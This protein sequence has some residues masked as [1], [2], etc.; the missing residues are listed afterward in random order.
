MKF[1][2]MLSAS[3]LTFVL[4]CTGCHQ[5]PSPEE[6]AE[7]DKVEIGQWMDSFAKAVD[8][9]DV[10][11]IMALY[12][13]DVLVYDLTP[14]LEYDGADA[15]RKDWAGFF[16]TVQL[17]LQMEVRDLRITSGGDV[18]FVTNL[19]RIT[20]TSKTGQVSSTWVR[21]TSGFRKVDGKWLDVHDHVSV[22][23][24]MATGK[25]QLDLQP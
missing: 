11:A 7:T 10:N 24:D 9:G 23:V 6:M 18:A 14:P 1:A 16:A 22:P 12:A 5:A 20:S 21:V 13:P 3:A 17:P 25:G 4:S 19:E 8:A 2:R 15:Y